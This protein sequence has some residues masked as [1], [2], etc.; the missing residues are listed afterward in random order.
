MSTDAAVA[1]FD[2][3]ASSLVSSI[4]VLLACGV[5]VAVVG[6]LASGSRSATSMRNGIS[7]HFG[8]ESEPEVR[9][10]VSTR[11]EV[12]GPRR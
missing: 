9:A 12:P 3:V 4:H 11:R 10:E 8:R 1:V 5:A 2:A 7:Q 6:Y